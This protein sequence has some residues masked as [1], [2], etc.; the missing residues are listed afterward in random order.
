MPY[1]RDFQVSRNIIV[2][3]DGFFEYTQCYKSLDDEPFECLFLQDVSERGYEMINKDDLTV[4][5][6]LLVMKALGKF[7]AISFALKDQQPEKFQDIVNGLREQHFKNGYNP[8]L[9]MFCNSGAMIVLNAITDDSDA[10]L[11]EAVLKL[12][13]QNQFDTMLNCVDG[14]EAEP[15]SVIVHGDMWYIIKD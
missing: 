8:E 5:H 7:H 9:E 13:E 4:E 14:N 10:H 6:I 12:Y 11:L 3:T 2:S 1:F 15:Y